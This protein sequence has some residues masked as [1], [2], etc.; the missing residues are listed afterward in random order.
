MGDRGEQELVGFP[1]YCRRLDI[2]IGKIRSMA[3][4]T[5]KRWRKEEKADMERLRVS[6]KQQKE[7]TCKPK[8]SPTV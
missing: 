8:S 3:T 1:L 2:P 6:F 7:E 5:Q 4:A